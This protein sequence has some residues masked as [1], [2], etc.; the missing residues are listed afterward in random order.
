[1]N[2]IS[3]AAYCPG[4]LEQLTTALNAAV[5]QGAAS[6]VIFATHSKE[7][8]CEQLPAK[9]EKYEIPIIG[10][11]FPEVLLNDKTY[12]EG[13]V[14]VGLKCRLDIATVHQLSLGDE[15]I[16]AQLLKQRELLIEA[17]THITLVDGL[18]SNIERLV[19]C[20]Y[21]LMGLNVSAIGGGAGALDFIQRP[22]LFT[23][24]GTLEDA[25]I[26]AAVQ[27]PIHIG[28]SHGWEVMDGPYLVTGSEQN[29]L[30]TLNYTPAFQVYREKVE[31]ASGKNFDDHDFFS[32]AKTYPL[33]IEGLDGSLTVRDPLCLKGNRMVCVG[34][35]PQNSTVYILKGTPQG[36]IKAADDAAYQAFS[37][38]R[39]H[40]PNTPYTGLIFDCISRK[41]FLEEAFPEELSQIKR[42]LGKNGTCVGALTLGEISN[43]SN[44][45]VS[46]LNKSTVVGLL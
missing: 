33:G 43:A 46:L 7:W 10:G 3:S 31:L 41:L 17:K 39:R 29:L 15:A 40:T 30:S 34:E 21:E 16:A 27:A 38:F 24:E 2:L 18:A 19:E 22:C 35:V 1:M 9:I 45:I 42:T 28:V 11:I 23:K 5:A 32:I 6:I 14:V 20:M 8:H 37:A 13:F 12:N 25:A 4:S 44:G 36:L 26:I